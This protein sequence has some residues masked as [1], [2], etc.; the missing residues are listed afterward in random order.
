MVGAPS[1]ELRSYVRPPNPIRLLPKVIRKP[2]ESFIHTESASGIVLAVCTVLALIIANSGFSSAYFDFLEQKVLGLTIHHWINDGLMTIFFFVVGMEIKRELVAGE[3]RTLKKAALPIA[4]ALGGMVV[5]AVVYL[6]LNSRGGVPAGWAI[7]MATDIAFALGVLTLFGKRVPLSL[8]IFLL[9]LA[10]VDDLGAV[11][12]IAFFYTEEVRGIG[13]SILAA[14]LISIWLLQR[15]RFRTYLPYLVFGVIAW[16]GTLY[17]GIHATIAGVLLGLL[18]PNLVSS[19][20]NNE[21]DFS[22]LDDLIHILHS[23]VSFG[24]MPIFAL[25]NAGVSLRG[26]DFGEILSSPIFSGVSLGLLLG[27]PIGIVFFSYL[28][29]RFGFAR[30]PEGLRWSHVTGVSLLAGIG[31]TMA[32]FISGL[33]LG[34]EHA[35]FAKSAILAGSLLA[36]VLGYI[37][38]TLAFRKTEA[39]KI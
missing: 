24:I 31:F 11:L 5:P 2:L 34:I 13:L 37:W 35:I 30:L 20:L 9:A 18:T 26:A 14:S 4:A 27:K 7:P 33:S 25:A 15:F 29:V 16:G 23:W 17:S 3:L 8:K 21:S 32:L 1:L 6:A 38:L 39:V 28:A 36:G 19:G 22:P 10:I 12:V